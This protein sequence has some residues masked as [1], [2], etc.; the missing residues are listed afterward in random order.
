[1]KQRTWV[2]G[3]LALPALVLTLMLAISY[4]HAPSVRA[5][6]GDLLRTITADSTGTLCAGTSGIGVGLAFDGTNLLISCYNDNTVTA[7]KP[8][9]GSQVAVH[10]I[11][12]AS[13]LGALAWDNG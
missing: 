13:S 3:W 2:S 10:S 1:M 9:D 11:A 5:L 12:G 4:S 7:V 6:N 8:A